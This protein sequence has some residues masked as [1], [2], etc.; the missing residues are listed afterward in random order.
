MISVLPDLA[1]PEEGEGKLESHP[2][3]V[4]HV[5][6]MTPSSIGRMMAIGLSAC[7]DL[8]TGKGGTMGIMDKWQMAV[9]FVF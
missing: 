9:H 4:V 3:S 8:P 7:D 2:E 5:G 6:H 1:L